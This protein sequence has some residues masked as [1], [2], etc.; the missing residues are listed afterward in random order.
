M[1]LFPINPNGIMPL[2]D[3]LL[4]L[5][6]R[7]LYTVATFIVVFGISYLF[8]EDIF[9][10]LTQPL[11]RIFDLQA[12]R[13]LIYT[14]LSE[15]F[16]SYVKVAFFAAGFL[17]FPVVISQIWLFIAPGLHTHE[18]KG[19]LPFLVA[20]PFLF[21]TGAAFAYYIIVPAAWTF[22]LQF[23]SSGSLTHLPIQLEARVGEYLSG[24]MQLL[25]AFGVCFEL[26]VL[27]VLL[28]KLGVLKV[29][30]LASK[31]KYA[32]LIILI[33]SALLTP[34]D[35]FSMIGLATPLYGLYELSIVLV[36]M[37]ERRRQ[38]DT[39]TMMNK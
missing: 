35:V 26:P 16:L 9:A 3:H 15:A 10:F 4:E 33:L 23:E 20:T 18:K 37:M 8:A 31:R 25:I 6:R 1:N 5:R 39:E 29:Q 27:L 32:F 2:T 12:G 11:A 7:L 14:G 22:F 21:M 34:P 30:M 38:Q 13:R 19:L 24:I 36:R 28:A 17:M